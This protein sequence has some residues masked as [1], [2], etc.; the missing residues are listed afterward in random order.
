MNKIIITIT[1]S[2][3]ASTA[4]GRDYDDDLD[5]MIEERLHGSTDRA[6]DDP[7]YQSRFRDEGPVVTVPIPPSTTGPSY[8]GPVGPAGNQRISTP[9]MECLRYV[10]GGMNCMPK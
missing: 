7:M 6:M 1:L 4:W 10:T 5:T 2:L 3:L 9:E 8:Y